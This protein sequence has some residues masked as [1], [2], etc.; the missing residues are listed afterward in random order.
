HDQTI[1]C[2]VGQFVQE[3]NQIVRRVIDSLG[4]I[5][6]RMISFGGSKNNISLLVKT[7]Y[8]NAA[9]EELNEGLFFA[10]AVK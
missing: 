6:V 10:E 1:I 4:E 7:R 5:P 8:K 2:I 9:M 3:N